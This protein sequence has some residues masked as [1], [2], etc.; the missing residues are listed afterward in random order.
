MNRLMGLHDWDQLPEPCVDL[1]NQIEAEG[2]DFENQ[3]LNLKEDSLTSVYEGLDHLQT[4]IP[5]ILGCFVEFLVKVC[6]ISAEKIEL[7][8]REA[9]FKLLDE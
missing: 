6:R 1:I 2:V 3:I 8:E 5:I 7:D 4:Y 9:A